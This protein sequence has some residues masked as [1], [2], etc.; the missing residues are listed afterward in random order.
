MRRQKRLEN[1]V[2]LAQLLERA[3]HFGLRAVV[4]RLQYAL[5]SYRGQIPVLQRDRLEARFPPAQNLAE[6]HLLGARRILADKLAHIALAR[7]EAHD[8]DGPVGRLR[9]D[10]LGDLLALTVDEGRVGGVTREP[11]HQLVE[12]Q[13][14]RVVAKLLCVARMIESPSSSETNSPAPR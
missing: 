13:H 5:F 4:A 8:R 1:V 7:D 9:F 3:I 14:D 11:Q 2:A 10:Q 12:E 6:R